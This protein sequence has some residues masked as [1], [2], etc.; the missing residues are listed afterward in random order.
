[1]RKMI[2]PNQVEDVKAVVIARLR[3][4][5]RIIRPR[6]SGVDAVKIDRKMEYEVRVKV[7][8]SICRI[9]GKSYL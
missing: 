5:V 6:V 1:M 2:N 7:S 9:R 3:A 4:R 8:V